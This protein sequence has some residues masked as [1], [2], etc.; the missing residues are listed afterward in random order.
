MSK[1]SIL[2]KA[3]KSSCHDGKGGFLDSV[4]AVGSS[5][6]D[7]FNTY[8]KKP[9]PVFRPG[10]QEGIDTDLTQRIVRT[11]K[12]DNQVRSLRDNVIDQTNF[13]PAAEKRARSIEISE[14]DPKN[15]SADGQYWQKNVFGAPWN[16]NGFAP[17]NIQLKAS[18]LDGPY[19]NAGTLRHELIHSMDNNLNQQGNIREEGDNLGNS[20]GFTETLKRKDSVGS[21]YMNDF[22]KSY[23]PKYFE[24]DPSRQDSERYAEYGGAIVPAY[25]V[26]PAS[27]EDYSGI[28]K[29]GEKEM[30][31]SP[32]Y[33]TEEFLNKMD[34]LDKRMAARIKAKEDLLKTIVKKK[35]RK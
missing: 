17:A 21:G 25:N 20:S 5:I 1:R 11:A 6:M 31:Y 35:K 10:E 13:T 4:K 32:R 24:A 34:E 3:V 16:P 29:P 23:D 14:L 19:G 28:Y 12:F 15:M 2:R 26:P 22:T 30:N 9:A 18:N 27:R 7:K 33:P 8:G